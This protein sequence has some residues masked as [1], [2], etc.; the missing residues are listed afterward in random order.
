MI[1][2]LVYEILSIIIDSFQQGMYNEK[3]SEN[4]G[5]GPTLVQAHQQNFKVFLLKSDS[6][7]FSYI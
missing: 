5:L 1:Y 3:V 2:M 7:V 4:I 6:K